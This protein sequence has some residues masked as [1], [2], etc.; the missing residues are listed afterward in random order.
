MVPSSTAA[1]H[2]R[3]DLSSQTLESFTQ[4][5][6]SQVLGFTPPLE[7]RLDH[8]PTNN[9]DPGFHGQSPPDD[10]D[11]V[12]EAETSY[13]CTW[14]PLNHSLVFVSN[15]PPTLPYRPPTASEILIPNRAPYSLDPQKS[16]N[17]AYLENESRLCEILMTL[18]RRPISDTQ[19]RLLA[20]VYEGLVMMSR[21]KEAEWSRQRAASIAHHHGYSVVNTG[22][23]KLSIAWNITLIREPE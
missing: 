18:E 19:E 8:R 10:L 16:I 7:L 17:R 15:P 4:D 5:I 12:L 20:R 14:A 13:H 22:I 3:D 6:A 11:F 9:Q 23:H 1:N 2:R 21:H